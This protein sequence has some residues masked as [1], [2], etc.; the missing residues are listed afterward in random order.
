MRRRLKEHKTG[1]VW[2]DPRGAESGAGL[3]DPSSIRSLLPCRDIGGASFPVFKFKFREPS[4]N[5][6]GAGSE[7][8]QGL[9]LL[10]FQDLFHGGLVW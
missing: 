3:G 1:P 2:F 7:Q 4:K 9:F 10:L 5:N 8:T 6:Y